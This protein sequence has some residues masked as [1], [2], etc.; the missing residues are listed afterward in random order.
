VVKTEAFPMVIMEPKMKSMMI[1]PRRSSA[2]TDEM[3]VACSHIVA[4]GVEFI[5]NF[6]TFVL[7]LCVFGRRS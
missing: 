3:L 6:F 7:V 2:R 4:V 5:A 1:K